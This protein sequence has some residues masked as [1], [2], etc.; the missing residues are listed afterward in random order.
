MEN[1]SIFLVFLAGIVAF[2]S[3]CVL[4]LVPVYVGD[5]SSSLTPA[6][7]A[8]TA[9]QRTLF[10]TLSF[11]AGFSLVFIMLGAAAGAMGSF[12]VS[13]QWLWNKIAGVILVGFGLHLLGIF[14]AIPFLNYEKRLFHPRPGL[15]GPARS[16][17]MGAAFSSGWSPC[18]GPVLG[19]VLALAVNSQTAAT[20]A[21]LM[22]VFSLG[23]ALPFLAIGLGLGK[24]VALVRKMGRF[25]AA[26]NIIAGILV[27]I[28][29]L[30]VFFDASYM[31]N[32]VL[33]QYGL[34]I[35]N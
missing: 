30:I 16:F 18:V 13:Y 24:A 15:S 22:A 32:S 31:I 23:L 8:A 9:R 6:G 35:S 4:P 10:K 26:L 25:L 12:I 21:V 1:L 19:G 29:G 28:I 3:P 14:R 11:V 5:V 17:M 7:A 27:I 2:L 34:A 20:G 33:R